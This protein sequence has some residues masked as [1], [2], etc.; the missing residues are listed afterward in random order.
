MLIGIGVF[1]ETI[2]LSVIGIKTTTDRIIVQPGDTV[3]VAVVEVPK[4]VRTA[5]LDIL[6]D[7]SRFPLC[8]LAIIGD[9]GVGRKARPVTVLIMEATQTRR[10]DVVIAPGT[11][12]N[13]EGSDTISD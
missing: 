2:V 13:T 3:L 5:K 9:I 8:A 6:A 12:H 1:A 4:T 7:A 10:A 11:I